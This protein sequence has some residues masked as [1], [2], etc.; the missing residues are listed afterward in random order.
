MIEGG[1]SKTC[2]KAK[3]WLYKYPIESDN[4]LYSLSEIA[5]K[6]L[7]LQVEA[8][9]QMLQIFESHAEFLSPYLLKR[10]A[11]PYLRRI[12]DETKKRLSEVGMPQVPMVIFAKGGHSALKELSE[13]GYN[14]VGLDWT[15]DPT[16]A[17]E[18]VKPG[19]VLQGNLDPVCL[20]GD[21]GTVSYHARE[22]IKLF[23]TRNYICNLGH[24]IYP[25]TPVESVQAFI[26]TVHSIP[27]DP[28]P[29]LP[30]L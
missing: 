4:L 9:A 17:R 25:E 10:I 3:S 22:M 24:G 8:G 18:V 7:V 20:F 21:T 16:T 15:I 6:Y 26:D 27:L 19:T 2:T 11:L 13:T 30:A 29:E 1:G 28:E 5:I 12:V 23:G 14:V